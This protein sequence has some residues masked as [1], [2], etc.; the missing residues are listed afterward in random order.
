MDKQTAFAILNEVIGQVP[1][2]RET[3]NRINLALQTIGNT[4][5]EHADLTN[6]LSEAQAMISSFALSQVAAIPAAAE[7][8][9]AASKRKKA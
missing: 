5:I 4:V 1:V 2:V 7:K 8:A 3:H 9:P 6:R